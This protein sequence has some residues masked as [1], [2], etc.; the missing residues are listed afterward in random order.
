MIWFLLLF[1]TPL[2]ILI[3][4][5]C[6][7]WLFHQECSGIFYRVHTKHHT[8]YTPEDFVSDTYRSPGGDST[9][10]LFGALFS[11]FIFSVIAITAFGIVPLWVGI[12]MMIEMALIALLNDRIHDSF[13]LTKSVWHRWPG[14]QKL[15][16]LHFLHHQNEQKNFGIITFIGDR[17]FGT[18]S[19]EK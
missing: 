2:L 18:F 3:L 16:R 6:F 14:Y 19:K 10:F 13:H 4:A 1:L 17:I 11:P 12:G 9:I 7:H 15:F 8:L 5:H